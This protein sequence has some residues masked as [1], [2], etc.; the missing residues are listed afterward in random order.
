MV[1]HPGLYPWSSY[2][3]N[4]FGEKQSGVT[5]HRLYMRLGKDEADR[6][7]AYRQ[8]FNKNIPSQTLDTIRQSTNKEWV[9]GNDCFKGRIEEL[10]KRQAEPKGRGGDRR[11]KEYQQ[12]KGINRV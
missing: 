6:N 7:A 1:K 2:R 12:S 10:T 9:L 4:A 3:S 8:L 5:P 11:S